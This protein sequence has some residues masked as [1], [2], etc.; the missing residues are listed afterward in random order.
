[1]LQ[2][3]SLL[4]R[5][6]LLG[7]HQVCSRTGLPR[8]Q[9]ERLLPLPRTGTPALLAV[10]LCPLQT[11]I[12]GFGAL[13][14][15]ACLQPSVGKTRYHLGGVHCSYSKIKGWVAIIK[16]CGWCPQVFPK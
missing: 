15:T 9:G 1:M 10:K 5:L 14:F 8:L 4:T 13:V 7:G 12:Q 16:V 6:E 11:P 2:L 3:F